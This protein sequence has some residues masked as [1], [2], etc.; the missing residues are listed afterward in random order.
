MCFLRQDDKLKGLSH[1]TAMPLCLHIIQKTC[2]CVVGLPST[3]LKILN[4]PEI[5]GTQRPHNVRTAST[6]RSLQ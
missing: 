2:Q 4:L 5:A 3:M 6:C 1:Q